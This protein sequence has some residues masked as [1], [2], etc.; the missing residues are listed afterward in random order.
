MAAFSPVAPPTA[1]VNDGTVHIHV[2]KPALAEGLLGERD[3]F[4]LKR[5]SFK[6]ATMPEKT[7]DAQ[8]V[9]STS[10]V[11]PSTTMGRGL[12]SWT[13]MLQMNAQRRKTHGLCK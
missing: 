11:E 5:M 1:A 6:S 13:L 12:G 9:P 8:L 3:L 10:I 4:A 7:G 2:L